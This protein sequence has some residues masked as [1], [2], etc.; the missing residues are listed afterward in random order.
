MNF[1]GMPSRID[2]VFLL[3]E[4]AYS[5]DIL[6]I[7]AIGGGPGSFLQVKLILKYSIPRS[8]RFLRN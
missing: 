7:K 1:H 3:M 4:I 5:L 6:S 2:I 8:E